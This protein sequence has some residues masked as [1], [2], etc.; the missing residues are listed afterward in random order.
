MALSVD[1]MG[2]VRRRLRQLGVAFRTNVS[3][4]DPT[5]AAAG[6]SEEIV[7]QAFVRDPDG[8]YIE[9]CNCSVVGGFVMGSNGEEDDWTVEKEAAVFR[10]AEVLRRVA[11]RARENLRTWREDNPEMPLDMRRV[12]MVDEL[13]SVS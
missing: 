3:V 11:Q 6:K 10:A 8:Y 12:C 7:D 9:F 2:A 1:D 13:H 4:P 5:A